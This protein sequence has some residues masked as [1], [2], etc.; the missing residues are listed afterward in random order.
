[1]T[2]QQWTRT[3]RSKIRVSQNL[4]RHAPKDL[5][6]F[7]MLSS[8]IGV[9]GGLS[10]ANYAAGN[11]YQAALARHRTQN[12]WPAVTIDLCG[13]RQ[14]GYV[15]H[16]VEDG[17]DT[18]VDRIDKMGVLM[19][20][21]NVVLRMVEAA[22]RGPRGD[23]ADGSQVVMGIT[24]QAISK[25]ITD[26]SPM[27]RDLRLH[28]LQLADSTRVGSGASRSSTSPTSGSAAAL[29]LALSNAGTSLEEASALL[30]ESIAVKLADMFSMARS[31]VDF[32]KPL[33]HY[34]I[35]SLVAIELRNWI[36]STVRAKVSVLDIMQTTSLAD[37]A[38]L[39]A[40]RSDLVAD[41]QV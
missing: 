8:V 9:I 7:I 38:T 39:V 28:S 35:D 15:E 14:V 24:A 16:R 12:G 6:F 41:K 21:V 17:D 40:I 11:A 1:M 30:A 10:Q 19:V 33:S 23:C 36:S 34:G 4:H 26:A 2:Y 37:F 20:D 22:I 13:V 18:L 29:L 5:D 25:A 31:D 32:G 3:F 27:A